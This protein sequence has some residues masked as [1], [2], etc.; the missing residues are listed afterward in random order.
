MGGCLRRRVIE[1]IS[2]RMGHWGKRVR[3]ARSREQVAGQK[4][5]R[6]HAQAG[7]TP[8]ELFDCGD[9]VADDVRETL[10]GNRENVAVFFVRVAVVKDA[11]FVRAGMV[12]LCDDGGGV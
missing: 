2:K 1:P 3:E 10:V 6:L 4:S 8:D 9:A 7:M 5:F 12:G 11:S